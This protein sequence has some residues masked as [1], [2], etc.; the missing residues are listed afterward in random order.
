VQEVISSHRV[1]EGNMSLKLH[2]LHSHLD[3]CTESRAAF[4]EEHDETSHY[5]ISQIEKVYSGK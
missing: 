5:D 1:V 3:F 2:F 4:S